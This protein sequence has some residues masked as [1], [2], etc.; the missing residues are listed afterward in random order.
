MANADQLALFQSLP[1]P[2]DDPPEPAVARLAPT[3]HVPKEGTPAVSIVRPATLP[4]EHRWREV[5]TASQTIGFV[6]RRSRRRSIGLTVNDDGLQVTAPAWVPLN[7][8][9]SVVCEKHAWILRKLHQRQERQRQMATADTQWQHGGQLP[10][11]GQRIVLALDNHC[12]QTHFDGDAFAP[13][14]GSILTLPLPRDADRLRV[15]DGT[16]AWLQQQARA[17]FQTRTRWFL[18]REGL[19]IRQLRLSSASTRWGSCSSDGNIML[20]WRLIHFGPDIIDYVIAHEIAHLREMNHSPAFWREV[21][22]ILPG[23]EQA[24]EALRHHQPG[25]LPLL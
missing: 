17:W 15:R 10:Y 12:T 13:A 18:E 21:G 11:L 1:E 19:E 22:R 23:F 2:S 5:Q 9:D 7:Q 14:D 8:I 6:L 4:P 16:H 20:N 24:R 3:V 25:T